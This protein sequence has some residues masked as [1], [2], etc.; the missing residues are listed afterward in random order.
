MA[1]AALVR[2]G[3]A[4]GEHAAQHT[5]FQKVFLQRL[6]LNQPFGYPDINNLDPARLFRTGKQKQ[7][8]LRQVRYLSCLSL[9][10]KIS[11]VS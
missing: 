10:K 5:V 1:V 2:L 6:P 4:G 8:A 9:R 7:S 3:P 11:T